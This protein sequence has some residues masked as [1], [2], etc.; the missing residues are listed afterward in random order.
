VFVTVT[1]SNGKLDRIMQGLRS[2]NS[3]NNFDCKRQIRVSKNFVGRKK[4]RKRISIKGI[5]IGHTK[6]ISVGGWL[7]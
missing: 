6:Q 7:D 2:A 3:C 4:Q 5:A 1:K